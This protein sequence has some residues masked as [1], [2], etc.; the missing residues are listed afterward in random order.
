MVIR[1]HNRETQR[2]IAAGF[3]R[4]GEKYTTATTLPKWGS[5]YISYKLVACKNKALV[6][7]KVQNTIA[8]KM[9]I[10]L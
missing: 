5:K 4:F 1:I 10:H 2:S 8:P 9:K 6:S 7:V 3:H